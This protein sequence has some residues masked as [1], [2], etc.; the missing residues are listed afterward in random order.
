ML[1]GGEEWEHRQGHE[2]DGGEGEAV[3]NEKN[4][5]TRTRRLNAAARANELYKKHVGSGPVDLVRLQDVVRRDVRVAE[6]GLVRVSRDLLRELR[7]ESAEVGK[8]A[9]ILG[10]QVVNVWKRRGEP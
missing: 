4:A 3:K 7:A 10:E 2:Q 1:R 6:L 5:S 9:R 8:I